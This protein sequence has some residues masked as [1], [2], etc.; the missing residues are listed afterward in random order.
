[1]IVVPPSLP[2][3]RISLSCIDENIA[4]SSESSL[5]LPYSTPLTLNLISFPLASKLKS[6]VTSMVKL[7]VASISPCK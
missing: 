2:L 6:P 4:K 7:S 1:M 3:N 5:N